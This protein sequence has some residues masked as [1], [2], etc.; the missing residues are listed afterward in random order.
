M[1]GAQPNPWLWVG[2]AANAPQVGA[3]ANDGV[4]NNLEVSNEDILYLHPSGTPSSSLIG[5]QLIGCENY[6]IWSRS[7]IDALLVKHKLFFVNGG[8]VLVIQC[9][10]IYSLDGIVVML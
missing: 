1:N 2:A 3:A 6:Q 5:F 9:L 7:M 4:N 8:P 10:S